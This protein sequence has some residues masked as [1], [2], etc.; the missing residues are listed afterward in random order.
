[1]IACCFHLFCLV[2]RSERLGL[3]CSYIYIR[4]RIYYYKLK[5][6]TCQALVITLVNDRPESQGLEVVL[7]YLH[8]CLPCL[9]CRGSAERVC[10]TVYNPHYLSRRREERVK[11]YPQ[12]TL[13]MS[14]QSDGTTCV[15]QCVLL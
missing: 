6:K 9:F 8:K 7:S 3:L 2:L 13:Y 10:I 5:D 14:G 1:M 11:M 12:G 4:A 15:L